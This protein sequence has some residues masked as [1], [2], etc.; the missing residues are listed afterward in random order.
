MYLLI[1]QK[2][3]RQAS[4]T[5]VIGVWVVLL[6]SS[7]TSGGTQAPAFAGNIVVILSAAVLLDQRIAILFA[8]LSA[9]EGLLTIYGQ[10]IGLLP[11]GSAEFDSPATFWLAEVICFGVAVVLLRMATENVRLAL[12]KAQ[13]ELAERRRVEEELQ[14]QRDFAVQVMDTLGQGVT[15][16]D[17]EA[18]LEYVNLAMANMLDTAQV[19]LI[20][21]STST[22][23]HHDD[24]PKLDEARAQRRRGETSTYEMRLLRSTGEIVYAHITGVPRWKNDK[25]IGAIAV[26]TDLTERKQAEDKQSELL[27]KIQRHNMQLET[28][29]EVARAASTTLELDLL[30]PRVV[31]FIQKQFNYYY[32]GLFLQD[33]STQRAVLRAATGEMGR[34]MIENGFSLELNE[35][36]MV[37]WCITH[38][39]PRFALDVGTDPVRFKNPYL[40]LT[41]SELAFPLLSHGDVIGAMTFQSSEPSAFSENDITALQTMVDQISNAIQNASLFADRVA[42]NAELKSRNMELERFTYTVSHD[43]RSPLI[44]IRG[45]LGFLQ[46]DAQAGNVDRLQAD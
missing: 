26:V 44:T 42:L 17:S 1:H 30:L 5:M 24:I 35:S 8:I 32:V 43:L 10:S 14:E 39:Q 23:T 37:G 38:K 18:K 12:Q 41:R 19:D 2:K 46:G 25:F 16:T 33:R 13:K 7:V 11:L 28:A 22:F 21:K 20:G 6:I 15:V 27:D 4:L 34:Q 3:I 9:A 31:E 40:P 36:S 45:F 29:A